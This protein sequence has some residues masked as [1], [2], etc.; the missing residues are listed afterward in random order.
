MNWKS[1]ASFIVGGGILILAFFKSGEEQWIQHMI[2]AG[3]WFVL[4]ELEE[5]PRK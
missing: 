4:S 1:I 5:R 2:A 3:I